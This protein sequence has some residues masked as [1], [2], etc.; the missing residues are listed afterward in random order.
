MDGT[1]PLMRRRKDHLDDEAIPDILRRLVVT[2]EGLDLPFKN[3]VDT[4]GTRRVA[5]APYR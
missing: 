4:A 1:A 3:H 2:L 5:E